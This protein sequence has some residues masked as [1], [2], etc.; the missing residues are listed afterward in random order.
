MLELNKIYNIDCL[1]GLKLLDD[2]SIDLIITSPP[3]NLGGKFHTGNDYWKSYNNYND[4]MPEELYQEWQIKVL[5]E[6]YRVLKKDGSMFYNHKPRIKNGITIHPLQFVL[7]SNF[8]LKQEIVWKNRSQNFD[9]IRFYPMSERI[10]WLVKDSKTKLFNEIGYSDVWEDVKNKKR[11]YIHKAT[12]PLELPENIIKCF[13]NSVIVLDIFM[14]I[15]TTALASINQ[16]KKF[17]GFEISEEYCNIANERIKDLEK[18][19]DIFEF[20]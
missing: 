12:F 11:H 6:C 2:E 9:K 7:K 3:Y 20:I 8:I 1:D 16:K 15:G 4:D 19:T 5:N 17:I 10:Y 14:G 13:K 18:Q